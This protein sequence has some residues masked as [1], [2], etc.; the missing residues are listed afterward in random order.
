MRIF[1]QGPSGIG[2]SAILREALAPYAPSVRG[3][4]VQRL[5]ENGVVIGFRA[6]TLENGFPP[7][8]AEYDREREGVFILRGKRDV[9][10]LEN[11]ILRSEREAGILLL[12]EIG[13]IELVSTVFMDA[14]GRIL[15]GETPCV[16][17]FKSRENLARA[18]NRLKL[19]E[20]C[21]GPHREL[22]ARLTNCAELITV[23][24]QNLD[25]TRAYIAKRL[26]ELNLPKRRALPPETKDFSGHGNGGKNHI[27]EEEI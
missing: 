8:S 7:P 22:E 11:A 21:S 19:G 9:S 20:A 5:T 16:G 25:E 26:R 17:V 6:V 13:G 15:S 18:S 24:G 12:D 14:L 27:I 2:K 3:F 1:L 10:A 4:V 23:T